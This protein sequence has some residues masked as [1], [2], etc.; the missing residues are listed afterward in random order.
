MFTCSIANG[1]C[2]GYRNQGKWKVR[3]K[4]KRVEGEAGLGRSQASKAPR[5]GRAL[6]SP[7]GFPP[8]VWEDVPERRLRVR[9]EGAPVALGREYA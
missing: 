9:T 3:G 2:K 4:E 7:P 8:R 6:L 1:G 5:S